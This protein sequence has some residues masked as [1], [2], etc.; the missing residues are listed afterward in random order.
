MYIIITTTVGIG[1]SDSECLLVPPHFSKLFL[2]FGALGLHI[3][4]ESAS[5][6]LLQQP[7]GPTTLDKTQTPCILPVVRGTEL[8][9]L[10]DFLRLIQGS[11]DDLGW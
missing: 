4:F 6:L 1:L 9:L 2:T 11:A 10:I 3:F 5:R 7:T 8:K